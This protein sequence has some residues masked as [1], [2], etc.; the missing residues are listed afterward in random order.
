MELTASIKN[1]KIIF[2]HRTSHNTLSK[3]EL[4]KINFTF[5]K[6]QFS[7]FIDCTAHDLNL[8]DM[9]NYPHTIDSN[10]EFKK[11]NPIKLIG[12]RDQYNIDI[13][14]FR[15]GGHD[16]NILVSNDRTNLFLYAEVNPIFAIY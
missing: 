14:R 12:K 10:L 8:Y 2:F 1:T 13:L 3:V 11:I 16:E 15:F 6:L 7:N 9:T 4:E 5:R